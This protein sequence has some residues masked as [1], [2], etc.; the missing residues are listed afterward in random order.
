MIFVR[1]LPVIF[2]LLL[3]SAHFSRLGISI[4]SLIFLLLP[5]LLLIKKQWIAILIKITL[6]IGTLEW[7]R[8]LIYYISQR[9]AINEPYLR[10]VIIIGSVALFTGL[11][12]LSFRNN[13]VIEHFNNK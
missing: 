6:I 5:F 3:L 10:L 8:A 4:L 12:I 1:L 11:S 13:K 9:Q 7:L 2:S